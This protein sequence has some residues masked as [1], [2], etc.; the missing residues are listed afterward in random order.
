MNKSGPSN[1]NPYFQVGLDVMQRR[2]LVIGGGLEADDKAGKLISAGA[3]VVVVSPS[4]NPPLKL[5]LKAAQLEYHKRV[6]EPEDLCDIFLV[7]NTVSGNCEFQRLVYDLSCNKGCLINTYDRPELSNF[8]MS[9]LVA[10]GHL[11]VGIS[12]S[13]TSP[14]IARRLRE[15]LEEIFDDME[16]VEYLNQLGQVRDHL[17]AT[18]PDTNSRMQILKSLVTDF[19]LQG[20]LRFPDGW[21]EHIAKLMTNSGE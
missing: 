17:K 2:C 11:R 14:S 12:T 18:I 5:F 9:A 3:K 19:E 6:F 20:K 4:L 21:Q 8:G 15:N 16:F 13:N 10:R 7:I 1:F